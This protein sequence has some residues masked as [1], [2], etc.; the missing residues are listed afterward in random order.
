VFHVWELE[1][2][3]LDRLQA[4]I[5]FIYSFMTLVG[6]LSSSFRYLLNEGSYLICSF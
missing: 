5:V 6:L 2:L 1:G 4:F 3:G